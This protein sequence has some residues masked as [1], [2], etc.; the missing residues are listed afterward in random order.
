MNNIYTPFAFII[1]LFSC[2]TTHYSSP[3]AFLGKQIIISEGGGFTGQTNQHIVLENG[4]VFARKSF[5]ESIVEIDRLDKKTVKDIFQKLERLNIAEIDFQ[6]PGNMT[7]TLASR[8]GQ[9]FYEVK[10]GDPD[11]KAPEAVL[12]LYQYIRKQI[13]SK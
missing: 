4:Q 10:W 3:E 5:P 7:Y 2:Q 9:D 1:I 13:T 6:H 12:E 8:S 11:I